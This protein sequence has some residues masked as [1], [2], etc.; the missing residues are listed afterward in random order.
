M[1]SLKC[2]LKCIWILK[3]R[4]LI[5]CVRLIARS[6]NRGIELL[7]ILNHLHTYSFSKSATEKIWKFILLF[8]KALMGIWWTLVIWK[9]NQFWSWLNIASFI[10]KSPAQDWT[11]LPRTHDIKGRSDKNFLSYGSPHGGWEHTFAVDRGLDLVPRNC[12]RGV[13]RAATLILTEDPTMQT[14]VLESYEVLSKI[15]LSDNFLNLSPFISN[16]RFSH[17]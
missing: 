8:K 12:R 17:F 14:E 1:N 3:V 4:I 7:K 2:L 10:L 9:K 15:E 11:D 16:L 5:L 6:Q 13:R